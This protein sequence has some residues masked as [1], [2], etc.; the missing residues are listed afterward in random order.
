[1]ANVQRIDIQIEL[2]IPVIKAHFIALF[3]ETKNRCYDNIKNCAAV[4]L[5]LEAICW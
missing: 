1:L 3:S 4:A 2:N 5:Y